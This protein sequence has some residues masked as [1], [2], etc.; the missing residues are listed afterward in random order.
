[1]Y[2][3][4]LRKSL[5]VVVL[6]F[7]ICSLM[8]FAESGFSEQI[9]VT[10]PVFSL[11]ASAVKAPFSEMVVKGN[12]LFNGADFGGCEATTGWSPTRC[13]AT[14]D[15]INKFEGTNCLKI[16]LSAGE[17]DGPILR[18]ILSLLDTSKYYSFSAP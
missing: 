16:T 5:I 4:R 2:K 12:T 3:G 1:M 9:E 6:V 13:S 14:I 11:P 10:A 17:T 7:F 18:N 15:S 8:T